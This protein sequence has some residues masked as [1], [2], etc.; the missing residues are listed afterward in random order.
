MKAALMAIACLVATAAPASARDS[1]S[2]ATLQAA[3]GQMTLTETRCAPG[4]ADCGQLRLTTRITTHPRPATRTRGSELVISAR[5]RGACSAVSPPAIVTAPDGSQQI[6]A[7]AQRI[8]PVRTQSTKVAI[9]V[10]ARGARWAW[11]EP[12]APTFTCM[13]FDQPGTTLRVPSPHGVPASVASRRLSPRALSRRHF[14]VRI[15]GQQTWRFTASDG[16]VVNGHGEWTLALRYTRAPAFA[17]R[18]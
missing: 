13:Y 17:G 2:G 5:G 12:L 18:R 11:L 1:L 6:L 4:T 7:G 15:R 9:S 16:T 10:N 3:S 14:A 8:D